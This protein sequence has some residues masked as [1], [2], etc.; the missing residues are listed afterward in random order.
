MSSRHPV[1]G[2]GTMTQVNERSI[3]RRDIQP[4]H[5]FVAGRDKGV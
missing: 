5:K 2:D 1:T 3:V 4:S